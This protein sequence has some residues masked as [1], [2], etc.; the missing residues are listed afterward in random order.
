MTSAPPDPRPLKQRRATRLVVLTG[1]AADRAV[2]LFEDSDPGLPEYR[3]WVT[4]GGGIDPGEDTVTAGLRELQE[5]TG[6]QAGAADLIGPL[7]TRLAV[8][9]YSDQILVQQETFFAIQTPRFDLDISGHTEDEKLTLKSWRWWPLPELEE[10]DDGPWVWP[11]YL[12]ELVDLAGDVP[13][14]PLDFGTETDE[15]TW[16]LTPAELRAVHQL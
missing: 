10:S 8:H 6:W 11:G 2:L 4:P 7:S 5:E 14:R 15:S 1:S 12:L 13:R 3:W 9:G 16:P